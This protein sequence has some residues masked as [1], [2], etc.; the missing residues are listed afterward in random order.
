MYLGVC[1]G[2][3]WQLKAGRR[4]CNHFP[5]CAGNLTV[6]KLQRYL[7][8]GA[9][10]HNYIIFAASMQERKVPPGRVLNARFRRCF[11]IYTLQLA[12]FSAVTCIMLDIRSTV[13]IRLLTQIPSFLK[14][15]LNQWNGKSKNRCLGCVGVWHPLHARGPRQAT[16]K[17]TQIQKQFSRELGV[18]V[19]HVDVTNPKLLFPLRL[20]SQDALP[21]TWG[22]G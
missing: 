19:G 13:G 9:S 4:V 10:L 20:Q 8:I 11:C 16:S 18:H 7:P 3:L 2:F 6:W 14:P 17:K 15:A 1:L 22:P 12:P 21:K 5:F